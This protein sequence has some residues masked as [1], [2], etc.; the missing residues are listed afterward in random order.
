MQIGSKIMRKRKELGLTQQALAEQL[1]ISFQAVSK[2]ENETA[3]PDITLLPQLASALHTTIDALLGYPTPV[4]TI[5]DARYS[6]AS[7][8]WGVAPSNMCYE[9]MKRKPPVKPYR[10]LDIGCGEGKDA[11]FFAKNGYQVTA[12]D[13]AATGVEKALALAERNGVTIEVFQADVLEYQ[14]DRE[15]D[16]IFSSG[17]FHFIPEARRADV[18]EQLKAHTA[19]GG[20]NAINVFVKKPFMQVPPDRDKGVR[21]P[22]RS[23]ELF[24]HYHD[25]QLHQCDEWIFDCNSGGVPHQ[26][27]MDVMLAEKRLE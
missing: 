3:Y 2:W 22:W 14:P 9:V 6:G 25:W 13:I 26:H 5:Y 10:V 16:I 1:H 20:L 19:V 18:T 21:T 7:Y 12:F 11:V 17:I 24:L 27:C 23:G 4:Q 8:Y 15:Y